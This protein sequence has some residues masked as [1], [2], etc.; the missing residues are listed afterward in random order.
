MTFR[1]EESATALRKVADTANVVPAMPLGIVGEMPRLKRNVKLHPD[2]SP[3]RAAFRLSAIDRTDILKRRMP[4][5]D[6]ANDPRYDFDAD[7]SLDEIIAQ[8]GKAPITDL[9]VLHG[10]FWPEDESVEGFLV[11]LHEWRGH[12]KAGPA[13]FRRATALL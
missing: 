8:Q 12:K 2:T 5:M 7:P 4:T 13:G 3:A 11:A 9:S 1:Q 10:G 6:R